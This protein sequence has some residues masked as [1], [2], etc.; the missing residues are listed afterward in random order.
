MTLTTYIL[1]TATVLLLNGKIAFK[2]QET[3]VP[4]SQQYTSKQVCDEAAA[5]MT[6]IVAPNS[7][8]VD[9]AGQYTSEDRVFCKEQK[10]YVDLS[11]SKARDTSPVRARNVK[12][13]HGHTH[14]SKK[15]AKA[16]RK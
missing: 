9:A 4:N 11:P 10:Q 14:A 5:S 3:Q 7:R 6:Q 16:H 8:S 2:M 1:T 13:A 12:P 15:K